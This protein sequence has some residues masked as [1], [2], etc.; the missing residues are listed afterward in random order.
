[1]LLGEREPTV[2]HTARINGCGGPASGHH[3]DD[4][5]ATCRCCPLA[6]TT[7]R[8]PAS[9]LLLVCLVRFLSLL[10]KCTLVSLITAS[11]RISCG[12][13]SGMSAGQLYN[14]L[15]N[16][17]LRPRPYLQ[18]SDKNV[19]LFFPV[20]LASEHLDAHAALCFSRMRLRSTLPPPPTPA[21]RAPTWGHAPGC[22]RRSL[23]A[24]SGS[25]T[26]PMYIT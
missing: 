19:F 6:H 18:N 21:F 14:G 11:S 2:P 9:L 23:T 25:H 22:T 26:H 10:L 24:P 7:A 15:T 8:P 17:R 16:F 3:D 4:D 5:G 1:M 13:D 12:D 20:V